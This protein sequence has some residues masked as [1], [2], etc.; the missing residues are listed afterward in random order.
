LRN[1]TPFGETAKHL[2]CD[3]DTKFGPAVKAAAKTCGLE[4]IHTPYEAPRANAISERFVGSVRPECLDQMLVLGSRQLMHVLV[5]YTGYFNASR[6]H[7]GLVP[8]TPDSC[9]SGQATVATGKS[10]ARPVVPATPVQLSGRKLM[11]VP[12]LNGLHHAYA[13]VT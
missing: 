12:V 8:Q 1:A 2:I 6:P 9:R 5:E 10:S 7:Q 4:V 13:W 11:A 3:S